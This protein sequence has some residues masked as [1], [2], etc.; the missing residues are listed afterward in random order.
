[1]KQIFLGEQ[2]IT[3]PIFKTLGARLH[4][5]DGPLAPQLRQIPDRLP[6]RQTTLVLA[7]KVRHSGEARISVF[8]LRST[9]MPRSTKRSLHLATLVFICRCLRVRAN[10]RQRSAGLLHIP[11]RAGRRAERSAQ[12]PQRHRGSHAAGDGPA[13]A[14]RCRSHALARQLQ[15][16]RH[17]DRLPRTRTAISTKRRSV[18]SN[19]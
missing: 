3:H 18:C 10:F 16:S 8:R 17:Y 11:H 19:T 15:A 9:H 2:D 6:R 1:M 4:H 14:D 12:D 5:P 13:H 7:D